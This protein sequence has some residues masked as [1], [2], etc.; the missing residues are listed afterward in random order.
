MLQ[1]HVRRNI[2]SSISVTTTSILV[3][4]IQKL[5]DEFRRVREEQERFFSEDRALPRSLKSSFSLLPVSREKRAQRT[6]SLP[7]QPANW[8]ASLDEGVRHSLTPLDEVVLGLPTVDDLV[9]T[10]HS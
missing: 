10:E 6:T 4:F 5:E 1:L 9:D 8:V 3:F 2:V 7:S